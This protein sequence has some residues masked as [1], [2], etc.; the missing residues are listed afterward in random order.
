MSK[1][2]KVRT[3]KQEDK[4]LWARWQR[5][6][7]RNERTALVVLLLILAPFFAFTL[8]AEQIFSSWFDG[9]ASVT[10]YGEKVTEADFQ[11]T[12]QRVG[13][14]A[15]VASPALGACAGLV[16]E[17][18]RRGRLQVNPYDYALYLKTAERMG[19]RVSDEEL[20][21]SIRDLWRQGEAFRLAG[22]EIRA[23]PG[24][25]NNPQQLQFQLYF[26][27]QEKLSELEERN[28]FDAAGWKET[29]AS[30]RMSIQ[31]FESTLRE[32]L[33]L[34]KLQR[35]VTDTV[36]VD[37]QEIYA[38]F[39][40][41]EQKRKLSW[42]DFKPT[43]D[44]LAKVG[45]SVTDEEVRAVFDADPRAFSRPLGVRASYVF[46][47]EK[48]FAERAEADVTD[49]DLID[50]YE[51]N[52]ND[53]RRPAINGAE[54]L[55]VLRTA[56]EQKALDDELYKPFDDV[57]AEVR[58]KLIELETDSLMSVFANTLTSKLYPSAGEPT[59][60]EEILRQSPFLR[61]GTT[62]YATADDAEEVFGEAF[63]SA[64]TGWFREL[65]PRFGQPQKTSIEPSK[66]SLRTDGG[67]V[68][69]TEVDVRT[70]RQLAFSE[71]EA[72]VR[73]KA[74]TD[75][76]LE[77]VAA[78]LSK[79]TEVAAAERE[80]AVSGLL[81]EGL[82]VEVDGESFLVAPSAAELRVSDQY[83]KRSAFS[84]S[85]LAEA[86]VDD[87][88]GAAADSPAGED[89][90]D[91]SD[92]APGEDSETQEGGPSIVR[93]AFS[94][95]TTGSLAVTTDAQAAACFLIRVDDI[96]PPDSSEFETQKQ[97]YR[98]QLLQELQS[99]YLAEWRRGVRREAD[100]NAAAILDS[101]EASS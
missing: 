56:E 1:S 20:G 4:S 84:L 33:V 19:I 23:Q 71:S 31:Q 94:E 21:A 8:P 39:R 93:A 10:L 87:S 95:E 6:L 2:K 32:L 40:K 82:T 3:D 12:A 47:P 61:S 90:G 68:L 69:Y 92:A 22:E 9:G 48:H 57:K 26:K 51:R 86:A 55:F 45:P 78:A 41:Q 65:T 54:D 91:A 11:K 13:S 75:R 88:D 96:V 17:R 64:V 76:A 18:D 27:S 16:A 35:F 37:D 97:R 67:R 98:G 66:N 36:N 73:E 44:L 85:Y 59:S 89:E 53:Y 79:A 52:R 63:T 80:G 81:S 42:I 101:T 99:T 24:A 70:P 72:E 100:P 25:M 83:V 5:W 49:D 77:L 74:V 43:A 30:T 62:E 34:A 58:E 28:A 7:A 14:V 46:V 15:A 29:V 60:L 50:Y 38:E